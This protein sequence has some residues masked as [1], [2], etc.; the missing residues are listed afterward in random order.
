MMMNLRRDV[1]KQNYIT[2]QTTVI[3]LIDLISSYTL[4]L[5]DII[6]NLWCSEMKN[7]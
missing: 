6:K 2:Y 3:Y 7:E 4:L 1:K 5:M